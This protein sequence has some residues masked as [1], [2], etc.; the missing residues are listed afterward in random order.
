MALRFWQRQLPSR[1]TV[2]EINTKSTG[3]ETEEDVNREE[4]KKVLLATS[5]QKKR[6]R[7]EGGDGGRL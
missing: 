5:Q 3:D 2:F 4:K 1:R 6:C 7:K